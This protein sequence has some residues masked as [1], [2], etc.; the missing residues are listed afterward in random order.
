[1]IIAASLAVKNH[2][3]HS[4]F[5]CGSDEYVL[6]YPDQTIVHFIPGRNIEFTVD[7]YKEEIGKPYWKID[8]YLCNVS[9][10]DSDVNLKVIDDNKVTIHSNRN[11]TVFQP[12]L[13]THA[14]PLS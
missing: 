5:F 9:N 14:S 3:D 8:L 10:V 6:C 4:Q 7:K 2:A 12:T 11:Q 13:W 1:M